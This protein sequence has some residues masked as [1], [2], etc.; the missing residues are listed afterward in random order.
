MLEKQK[1]CA[2]DLSVSDE[3]F[4]N[5]LLEPLVEAGKVNSRSSKQFHLDKARTSKVMNGKVDVPKVL[6]NALKRLGIEDETAKCFDSFL[7]EYFEVS[8]FSDYANSLISSLDS[9]IPIE[10]ELS[11]K[12][13][14]A[15]KDPNR[16]F[17]CA[18][19]AAIK[20]NNVETNC[21]TIWHNGTGSLTIEIGDILSHGFGNPKKE[22][23]I[24]VIP[25]NNAFD[26]EITLVHEA[27]GKPLV[28]EKTLHGK[29]LNRMMASG[30][31]SNS[32]TK[33]ISADLASREINPIKTVERI[34]G[35]VS[36]YETGTIARIEN[37]KS[38]FFLVALS[39]F[40]ENNCAHVNQESVYEIVSDLLKTYDECGQGLD[41]YLPLLGT[42]LSRANLSHQESLEVIINCV[43]KNK[44]AVHGSIFITV[45]PSDENKLQ[46]DDWR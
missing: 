1:S 43:K 19:I 44:N 45:L 35:N 39:E 25:V 4:L 46:L 30:E 11:K 3:E 28:S 42:G 38:I 21:Q 6:R 27:S 8:Y 24:V 17:S 16:F 34:G 20:A 2:I 14:T 13:P 33:R 29:W 9:N 31:N 22:K 5:A 18:L 36:I 37:K 12:L 40:D 10:R 23:S 41:I 7:Q 26:T 15:I 32:I